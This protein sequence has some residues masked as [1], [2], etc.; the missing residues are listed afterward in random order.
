MAR[1]RYEYEKSRC[2]NRQSIQL[3]ETCQLEVGTAG[4]QA[5]SGNRT[6]ASEDQLQRDR[7]LRCN[8]HPPAEREYCLQRM[9]GEGTQSGSAERGGI[10]RERLVSAKPKQ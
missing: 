1:T 10:L 3:K 4:R 9:R 7:E 6:T 2:F 5:K 8:A